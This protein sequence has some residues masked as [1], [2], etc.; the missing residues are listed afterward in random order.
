MQD[1][2]E[3]CNNP[4]YSGI[5]PTGFIIKYDD[6]ASYAR[7]LSNPHIIRA[8][9]LKQG[10][11]GYMFV[12][13]RNNPFT[14]TNTALEVGDFS[15]TFTLTVAGYIPLDGAEPSRNIITPMATERYVVILRN[16]WEHED[17]AGVVDNRWQVYGL[18][19]GLRVSTLQ[20]TRYENNDAWMVEL[21]ETGV[22]RA[23]TFMVIEPACETVEVSSTPIIQLSGSAAAGYTVTTSVS[24]ATGLVVINGALVIDDDDP[25]KGTVSTLD[26]YIL[27][28]TTTDDWAAATYDSLQYCKDD[29]EQLKEALHL[30]TLNS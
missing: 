8:I 4:I 17:S 2:T 29:C 22:R 6:I 19:R 16:E 27:T 9:V 5:A 11:K 1:I 25:S 12:Q 20:Q 10:A 13:N 3:S 30:N 26:G 28:V 18:D 21:Q 23:S 24:T 14:G 15:N 7:Y